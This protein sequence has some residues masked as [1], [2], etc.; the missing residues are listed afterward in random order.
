MLKTNSKSV[1]EKVRA[2]IL[3]SI[4]LSNYVGYEGYPEK[5]PESVDGKILMCRDIF[6]G[7]YLNPCN[8]RRYGSEYNCF[9][10]WLRCVPS[11]MTV[12]FYYHECREILRNWMEQTEQEADK[13]SDSQVWE[14]YLHLI[15][16]EFFAMVDKAERNK[17]K[18]A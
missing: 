6:R 1:K 5:E 9:K 12:A 2:Y 4:D 16:R 10:E 11:A 7:E 18:E 14:L 17:G 15:T 8:L 3:E 13:Y